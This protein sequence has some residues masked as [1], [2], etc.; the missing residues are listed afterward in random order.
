MDS[1]VL[2]PLVFFTFL[3]A[4]IIG[5]IMLKERTKRSAHHLLSQAMARGEALDPT[6]VEKLS[7]QMVSE[8]DRA[9][10]SL[11]KGVILLALG[12]GVT[13]AVIACEAPPFEGGMF[14][15]LIILGSVG[16]AFLA[17]AIVDYGAQKRRLAA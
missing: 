9:R 7:E 12:A 14:A 5:P 13:G 17:L 3:G 11:G 2:V 6:L 8:G 16:F 4:V 15:P 10:S 1:S